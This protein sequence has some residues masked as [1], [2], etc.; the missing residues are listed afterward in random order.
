MEQGKESHQHHRREEPKSNR[1]ITHHEELISR[2]LQDVEQD[3]EALLL[4]EIQLTGAGLL[5][6]LEQARIVPA[7]ENP[8]PYDTGDEIDKHEQWWDD[9]PNESKTFVDLLEKRN[10]AL[11]IMYV[12]ARIGAGPWKIP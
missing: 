1:A 6:R 4:F 5:P 11:R 9:H 3:R 7:V 12:G 8:N 2:I 10:D